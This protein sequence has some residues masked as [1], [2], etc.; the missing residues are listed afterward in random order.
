MNTPRKFLARSFNSRSKTPF[1]MIKLCLLQ[2]C[3]DSSIYKSLSVINCING[4]GDKN[5]MVII[6]IVAETGFEKSNNIS[7]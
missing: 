4:F 7:C 1:T 3:R 5:H 2:S 6:S